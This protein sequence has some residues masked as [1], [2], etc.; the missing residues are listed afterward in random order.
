MLVPV[1]RVVRCTPKT[2]PCPTCGQRGRRKRCLRRRIRSL[3]YRQE[4]YLDVHYAEYQARC[5]CCKYFRSWP[6]AVPAKA[7][8]DE[9]V[10]AAVVDRI[11]ADGLNVLRT[12]QA[13][14]RDFLLDLSEG[15]IYDCLRW[16][17][18]QLDL[19]A[20]RQMVI[21]KFSG[22]LCLDEIHLGRFTL[23]LATD[24]ISDLPVAFALVSRNDK[25]H[26]RRWLNNLKGWG[27]LPGVVVTDGSALYPEVLAELWPHARHQLCVF[28]ILKDINDL[29]LKGVRRLAR[30]RRR[31]GNAGRKRRRGRPSKKQ[32]VARAAAGPTLKEKADFILKHRFL[33]VKNTS[34]LNKEQWE[35]L[36]QM[37]EYLPELRTLW[38]FAC[39]VRR[40]FEKE[41]RVQTLFKRREALLRNETYQQVP[42]LA[43]AM[44]MLERGK[45]EKAVAF[46]YSA[47]AEKV[48]TNNHVER[49]NRKF[50]FA[51]KSRYKW[52]RRKWVVRF[53]LLALDHW[54][55]QAASAQTKAKQPAKGEQ[56]PPPSPSNATFSR[57]GSAR[58][59]QLPPGNMKLRRYAMKDVDTTVPACGSPAVPQRAAPEASCSVRLSEKDAAQV[60]AAA[61]EP[62]APNEAALRAARRFLQNHE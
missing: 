49:V 13:M 58:S 15:F 16:Q 37:F 54:W 48:R 3:A 10:R 35:E 62:P 20:H 34:T 7:D 25:L 24:P 46:V 29:I 39:E 41:A 51:E 5:R 1:V 26:M 6:L 61:E 32:Q 18:K 47:A 56:Q 28:H 44:E 60:M 14:N 57:W 31:R 23:L 40:L 11:I 59:V 38:Y 9:Q 21:A 50:R 30:A 12:Q 33:I 27:L 8:Y 17:I 45:F 52:R 42:E 43:E 19:P 22:T 36:E 55:R 2:H 53:V 4:A